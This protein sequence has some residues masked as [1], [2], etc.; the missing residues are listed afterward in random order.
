M[1]QKEK[2]LELYYFPQCPFCQVVLSALRV[3]ALEEK[4][5]YHDIHDEPA[6]KQ[7]LI[8][9][10]GRS[11]VPVLYVDGAPMRESKDIAAWLHKYA[12]EIQS[13]L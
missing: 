5:V 6:N 1:K 13:D 8:E 9:N 11:T 3:T 12:A 10:T 7:F 4:I 2:K